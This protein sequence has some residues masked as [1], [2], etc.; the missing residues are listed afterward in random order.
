MTVTE[1]KI[2][3]LNPNKWSYVY[4]GTYSRGSESATS[5]IITNELAATD[6]VISKE[7]GGNMGILDMEFEFTAT[8]STGVFAEGE[9]YTLSDD[10]KT[11]T[12]ALMHGEQI[13][14]NGV[15]LGAEL[16][17]TESNGVYVVTVTA[18]Q[19]TYQNGAAIEVTPELKIN[20][21]NYYDVPV[22]TGVAMDSIPYVMI[23]FVAASAIFFVMMRKR[24]SFED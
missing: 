20:F 17:V 6:V 15:P 13:T 1:D 16:T 11:A 12:F 4:A 24:I 19:D 23:L 5:G 18:G 21:Y 9:G 10:G 7:V 14:L 3:Y 8:L 22:D 2:S